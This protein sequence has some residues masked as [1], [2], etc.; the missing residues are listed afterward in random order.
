MTLNL[1][2]L[3]KAI[4]SLKAAWQARELDPDNPFLPDACIQ[5][6]EYT[7]ERSHKI[8]RRFLVETEPNP[9]AMDR[10]SFPDLIRLGS[11]RG[12]ISGDWTTWQ[13][14]RHARS[15]TSHTYDFEKS[16]EVLSG[17]PAFLE[18]AHFLF[19]TL[20]STQP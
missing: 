20:K 5:R 10:L 11:D 6:F 13:R 12:L 15:L 2:V 4:V 19:A 14:Y 16:Q 17:I 7:Y 8:L 9:D 18:E 1:D 3:E